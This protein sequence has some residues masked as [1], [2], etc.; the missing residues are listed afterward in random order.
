MITIWKS[1][2]QPK[3][4]YCSQLWSPSDQTN[5][6][7]LESVMRP[8]TAKIVHC[9]DLDYWDRLKY[10][11]LLSQERRR[12]RYQII[13]IWKIAQ[14]LIDGYNN[15]SFSFS[16]RRGRTATIGKIVNSAPS[17][18]KRAREA[19]LQVKGARLFNLLPP[20][21]RNIDGENVNTFKSHLDQFL[22]NIPD[23]PT[24]PGRPRAAASNSLL[25]QI[26]MGGKQ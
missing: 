20:D 9:E 21:I 1:I 6:C 5:I 11:Q 4:D 17:S 24:I 19:S 26:Q 13:L 22:S 12:E 25:D 3:L 7:K 16:P 10:L 14:G 2:V 8:F 18:V 15:I 23:Q